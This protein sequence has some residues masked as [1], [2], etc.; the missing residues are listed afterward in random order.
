MQSFES[1]KLKEKSSFR[2]FDRFK[3]GAKCKAKL[4][5]A[6]EVEI[7]N[8]SIGGILVETTRRLN[9]N[10]NYRI[11]IISSDNNEVITPTGTVARAFLRGTADTESNTVPLYEVALK[12]IGLKDNE[13]DFIK[14]LFLKT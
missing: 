8:I 7:K 2:T 9:V 3:P 6:D 14:K 13:K 4:I 12:F 11:Q 5:H 1:K 10:T